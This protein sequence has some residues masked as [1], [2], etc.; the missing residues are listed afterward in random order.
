MQSSLT[1][2]RM[3]ELGR[4]RSVKLAAPMEKMEIYAAFYL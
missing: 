3:I 1:I 2:I 4:T